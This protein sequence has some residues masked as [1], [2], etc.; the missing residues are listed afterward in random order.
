[1]QVTAIDSIEKVA[2]EDWDALTDNADPFV[3]HA[4]LLCLERHDCLAPQGWYPYHLIAEIDGRVV[5]ALPLYAKDNSYGEFVFDW[6]WAD[7]Y[8][9]AGGNYY[10]KF[11]SAIPFTPVCGNRLLIADSNGTGASNVG[12][13][14]GPALVKAA[15]SL[16]MEAN[17]S[18]FHCLFPTDE[19]CKIFA[20]QNLLL[21]KGC[22]YQ[23]FNHQYA[24]FDDFLSS[25]SSKKRKQIKRERREMQTQNIEI[26]VL[27]GD[28]ITS[29]HWQVYY[30]FYCDTFHRKWGEPRLT[31]AFFNALTETLPQAPVLFM[32]K[33]DGHYVAGAFAM[34]GADT[35]YGRHWGCAQHVRNLHFELC[36][37]QTIEYCI[38]R[39][40]KRL[41]AGVQG[42]HKIARGFEPV[43][44]WSAHWIRDP[45]FRE[46]IANFIERETSGMDN[47]IDALELH[48]AYR[49]SP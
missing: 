34:Q 4:F 43:A 6:A 23:W 44:T 11:V 5:G 28:Q 38:T 46:A 14:V 27:S 21:R 45:R 20:D 40:L 1:M 16:T 35:L 32:A 25:L 33:R 30:K 36:Y 15:V 48:S 7:A 37:Y 49:Q 41:D 31:E 19:N 17:A 24:S 13:L 22:Q 9:R 3:S 10:P 12:A 8:E 26:E 39:G 2:A 47:Y 42:E 18:S 29:Q